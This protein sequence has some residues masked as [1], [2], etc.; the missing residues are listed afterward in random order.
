MA[1]AVTAHLDHTAAQRPQHI[2]ESGLVRI[3]LI[4][5]ALLFLALVVVLPLVTIFMEAF[6]KGVDVYVAS[7]TEPYA[8]SA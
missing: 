2:N 7:V 8:L 1:G 6:K 5:I 3:I 4:T